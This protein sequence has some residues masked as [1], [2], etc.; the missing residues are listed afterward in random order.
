MDYKKLKNYNQ[1]TLLFCKYFDVPK[2][3]T[4]KHQKQ[5]AAYINGIKYFKYP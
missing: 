5:D 2:D 1:L 4:Y 3:L